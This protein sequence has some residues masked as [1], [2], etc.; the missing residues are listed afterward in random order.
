MWFIY[1]IEYYSAIKN[2]EIVPFEARWMDLEIV[3]LSEI[4]DKEKYHMIWL[5]YLKSRDITLL[6]KVHLVQVMVFPVV[7]DVRVVL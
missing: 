7:M 5:I 2:N 6:T 3:I 4:R 1:T